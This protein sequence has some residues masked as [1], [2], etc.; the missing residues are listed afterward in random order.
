VN[1]IQRDVDVAVKVATT[2]DEIVAVGNLLKA[3]MN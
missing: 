3:V 1:A 2:V